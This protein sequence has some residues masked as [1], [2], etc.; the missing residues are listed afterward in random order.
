MIRSLYDY[1]VSSPFNL[2]E[3][4]DDY[5]DNFFLKKYSE[6]KAIT[7]IKKTD[8]LKKWSEFDGISIKN[9]NYKNHFPKYTDFAD[10]IK[11]SLWFSLQSSYIKVLGVLY[12]AKKWD[13]TTNQNFL[14][15]DKETFR[16]N[17]ILIFKEYQIMANFPS[18][19]IPIDNGRISLHE[20]YETEKKQ[21]ANQFEEGLCWFVWKTI[22]NR[23]KLSNMETTDRFAKQELRMMIDYAKGF[24]DIKRISENLGLNWNKIVDSQIEITLIM[25]GRPPI[26]GFRVG[27]AG[28]TIQF[29]ENFDKALDSLL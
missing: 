27:D 22:Q 5:I 10:L 1:Y 17:I 16:N 20:R 8:E 24:S 11:S 12:S 18:N 26:L 14:I 21:L 15:V 28:K 4:L 29:L 6:D 19:Q 3:I 13:N 9:R 2:E 25:K 23:V 7:T